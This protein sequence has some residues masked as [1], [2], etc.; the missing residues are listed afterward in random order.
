MITQRR[1]GD[2]KL[3]LSILRQEIN[4]FFIALGIERRFL[5]KAGQQFAHGT[6]IQQRPGK[7]VLPDLTRLFEN[8]N[9]FFAELRVGIGGVVLINQLRKTQRTSHPRGPAADDNH[10]GF[11]LWAVDVFERSAENQHLA[12]S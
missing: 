5:L 9:I 4:S 3:E 2:G 6:W 12:S 10:V 11:H 1:W 8:V 7:A